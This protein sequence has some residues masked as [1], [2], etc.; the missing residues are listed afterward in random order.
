MVQAEKGEMTVT[1]E[2][3]RVLLRWLLQVGKKFQVKQETM[4]ICVQLIDY[5]LIFETC[6][7]DKSNFQLLGITA[8]FIASKYNEIHTYEAEKY[9]FV[10]DGLYT[11]SQLF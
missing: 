7:I 1:A 3:R 5:M 6:L 11:F 9:V 2:M 10:C 4:H 8:L